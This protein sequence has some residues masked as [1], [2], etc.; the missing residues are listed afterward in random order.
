MAHHHL[1]GCGEAFPFAEEGRIHEVPAS[2]NKALV[3]DPQNDVIPGN[4]AIVLISPGRFGE[5]LTCSPEAIAINPCDPGTRARI[6]I[7]QYFR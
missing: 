1:P 3:S 2:G 4:N 7:R 6:G 5:S